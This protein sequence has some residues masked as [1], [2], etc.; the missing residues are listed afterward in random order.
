MWDIS[1]YWFSYISRSLI[2]SA[3]WLASCMRV[4]TSKWS[5]HQHQWSR[6]QQNLPLLKMIT[7]W[8]HHQH[9]LI[10]EREFFQS[11]PP[12][13]IITSHYEILPPSPL[14]YEFRLPNNW[15]RQK[16]QKRWCRLRFGHWWLP[17][18]LTYK[19][20]RVTNQKPEFHQRMSTSPPS[21]PNSC[22]VT[23]TDDIV[24]RLSKDEIYPLHLVQL[25]I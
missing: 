1:L 10:N 17:W 23:W 16:I 15:A 3:N 8:S 18:S 13:L 5:D 22:E 21:R 25:V 6:T 20:R 12:P 4:R 7:K 19:I 11:K 9:E 2:E 24:Q 14:I